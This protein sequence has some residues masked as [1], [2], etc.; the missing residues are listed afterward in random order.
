[1]YKLEPEIASLNESPFLHNVCFDV[2]I[3]YLKRNE[4]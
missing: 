3:G 1:M 4:S 2:Y